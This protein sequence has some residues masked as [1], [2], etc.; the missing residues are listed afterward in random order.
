M[1]PHAAISIRHRKLLLAL[2]T[3]PALDCLL[4]QLSNGLQLTLGPV[5]ILQVFRGALLLCFVAICVQQLYRDP[6]ASSRIPRPAVGALLL[7]MLILTKEFVL[8]GTIAT[9]GVVAYGQLA[10]W[11]FLWIVVS[12]LCTES[13]QANILLRGLACGA[14][15]TA[16]SVILGFAFGG[17]NYYE[18]DAVRSSSGWFN[19]A[20]MITGILVS[21]SI[22]ILYLGRNQRNWLAP[23]L[24]LFCCAACILTYARAGSVAMGAVILWLIL[25][26]ARNHNTIQ[27]RSVNIFLSVA[28]MASFVVAAVV[29]AETLFSRWSDVSDQ[30]KAGS[31]RATIWRIAVEG[32]VDGSASEQLLGRGYN[33]MSELLFTNYGDDVKHT[34]NDALDMLLVGGAAGAS[35]LLLF[36]G[37]WALRI[38]H[39]SIWTIEGAGAFAVLINYLCHAQFT[40]QIWGTDAMTYYMVAMTSF[41]VIGRT[42]RSPNAVH[43][44]TRLE[45]SPIVAI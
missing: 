27:W 7:L 26:T 3:I 38:S 5:S 23:L 30:D 40:G 24:A 2:A 6:T 34:H 18:D 16:A 39:S 8:T 33:S 17:L 21:G 28:L 45:S 29:P 9:D 4:N 41:Y 10:Y 43:S 20:K 37:D 25:W 31:G 35:F 12:L 19:T 11:V 32:Y 13:R 22:V 1:T 15:L 42:S 14:V 36:I 44:L